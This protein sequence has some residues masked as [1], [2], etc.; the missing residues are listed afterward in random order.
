MSA[1]IPLVCI[2]L[3]NTLCDYTGA[4]RTFVKRH[5]DLDYPCPDP[6]EYDFGRLAGWPWKD[7]AGYRRIHQAAVSQGL[8]LQERPYKGAVDA[9]NELR[10]MGCVP[11]IVTSRN[12]DYGDTKRW[13]DG[14]K[15]P[16]TSILHGDK[17]MIDADLWIEDDPRTLRRLGDLGKRTLRPL[18]AYCANRLPGL[19]FREWREVPNLLNQLITSAQSQPQPQP[20][21][22]EA[23]AF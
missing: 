5:S 7:E 18:H 2:D 20:Q 3:D 14:W 4:L 19:T 1:Q 9:V 23:P 16:Y 21:P 13:L 17:T 6:Q 15:I 12:D 10:N 8:Y 11:I 22:E